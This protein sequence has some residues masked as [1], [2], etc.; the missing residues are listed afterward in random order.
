MKIINLQIPS[1]IMNSL[2]R[3]GFETVGEI[4]T[5]SDRDLRYLRGI[6][7]LALRYLREKLSPMSHC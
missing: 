5:A 7:P 2:K 4:R 1:R 6:G 3:G